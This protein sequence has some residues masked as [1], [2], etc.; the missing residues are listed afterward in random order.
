MTT[1][2]QVALVAAGILCASLAPIGVLAAGAETVSNEAAYKAAT[3]TDP[4]IPLT[5][6]QQQ[7]LE[8]KDQAIANALSGKASATT[9]KANLKAAGVTSASALAAATTAASSGLPSSD[10]VAKNQTPQKTAYW[11][12]PA[13]VHEALGQLHHEYSQAFLAPELGTTTAGTAWSGGPT[14]T[15]HPVPDVLNK[16]HTSFYYVPVGVSDSPGNEE[17]ERYKDR[18]TGDIWLA[19][20]PVVGNAWTLKGSEFRLVGHP[21]D[22]AIFHW[23]DIYGYRIASGTTFTKYEDSVHSVPVSI[24]SWAP[25]VP[26][27]S[28]LPSHQ[29]AHI[30]G[31]RGYVW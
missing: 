23:F 6:Y 27:Y 12:G 18:L 8:L 16:F 25:G 20:A 15:G 11:C 30:I 7:M 26:A 31:G 1:I 4:H 21:P 2:K 13:T 3:D 22:R 28:E 17:V 24:I 10:H 19:D 29:I 5:A 14:K 9:T